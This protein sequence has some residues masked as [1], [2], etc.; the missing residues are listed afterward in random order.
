MAGEAREKCAVAGVMLS[1]DEPDHAS[2]YAYEVLFALQHRGDEATGMVSR[3]PGQ[4]L[5][6][7]RELGMVKDVYNDVTIPRLVGSSVIGHNRYSTSGH[8]NLNENR[9]PQPVIDESIGEALAQNGNTP[10][11][12]KMDRL[13]ESKNLLYGHL[14]DSEKMGVT[15]A[16]FIR[17]GQDFPTAIENAYPYFTGAFSC[18]GLHD[19]MMVAFRDSYGIRPLALGRFN[20][21]WV[22]SSETCGLDILNA[23]YERE[24]QPGELII[25]T[26][27]GKLESRQVAERKGDK[28]DIFEPVYF[29]RHDSKLRGK[30]VNEIR[31]RIG[32]KLA[33]EHGAL[34][35]DGEDVVVVPVPDTSVPMA[36]GYGHSLGL[37]VTQAIVKNRYIGRTFMQPTPEMRKRQLRRKHNI[38]G[39]EEGPLRGKHVIMVDD[40]I[41]RLNTIPNLVSR[42]MGSQIGAKS[43]SVLIGSP[44]VRFPDFY[45][46][47]TPSQDE[48]PAANMT[49]E[50]MRRTM[51][52]C[53]YLGFLPLSNLVEATGMPADMFN[54][55]CF[56]G[57][58][59]IDIGHNLRNIRTPAS[60]EYV[61]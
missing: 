59:P 5:V 51:L 1:P 45:G 4:P 19:N 47:D 17:Q 9:H 27:D 18:V 6:A 56:N 31:R 29:T 7:H 36:E 8:K 52:D 20:N 53:R 14:N 40:S 33:V 50:Q 42:M 25:I 37:N 35:N 54:L 23:K 30:I 22:V 12:G 21:S 15:L 58:Y 41:V 38:I 26:D 3:D 13:L 49:V 16:S 44:P 10:D 34:Y 60:M 61:Y 32:Q 11:A 28:L 24:V 46:I 39:S 57:E 48:L 55:S 43:V 2:V